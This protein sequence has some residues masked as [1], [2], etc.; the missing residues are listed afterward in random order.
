MG[1]DV[2]DFL[3]K[4]F[5]TRHPNRCGQAAPPSITLDNHTKRDL[6]SALRRNHAARSAACNRDIPSP[7]YTKSILSILW[8]DHSEIP[9]LAFLYH[10]HGYTDRVEQ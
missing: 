10:H 4:D 9:V 3:N 1:D 5:Q 2:R 7:S 6:D 8:V